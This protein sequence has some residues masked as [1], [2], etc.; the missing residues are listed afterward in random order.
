[1]RISVVSELFESAG[2]YL[3]T[4]REVLRTPLLAN[5]CGSF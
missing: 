1:M 5:R 2:T 3:I 4:V